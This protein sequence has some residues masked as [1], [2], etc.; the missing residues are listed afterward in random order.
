MLFVTQQ[1]VEILNQE[2]QERFGP[3]PIAAQRF[4]AVMIIKTELRHLKAT[5]LNATAKSASLVLRADTPLDGA[6]LAQFVHQHPD[7]AYSL[8]PDG[9]LGHHAHP[10]HEDSLAH[11]QAILNDLLSLLKKDSSSA[12]GPPI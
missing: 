7:G 6:R 11:A 8:S 2:V 3:P 9:R 5:A 12:L 4:M 1:D 10:S